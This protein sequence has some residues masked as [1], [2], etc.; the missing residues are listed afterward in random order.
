MRFAGSAAF[1]LPSTTTSMRPCS[2]STTPCASTGSPVEWVAHLAPPLERLYR[3]AILHPRDGSIVPRAVGAAARRACGRRRRRHPGRRAGHRR[4]GRRRHGRRRRRRLHSDAPARAA[5][6]RDARAGA[7]DRAIARAPL[8]AATLRTRRLRLLAAT[9]RRAA[10]SRR[11][12]RRVVR[13]GGH[14]GRRDDRADPGAARRASSSELVGYRPTVT[15][16]WAG[17]WGTT[18]DLVPLVGQV[19]GRTGVWVAGGYSG[20]GNVLGLACGDLVARAILGEE[21]PELEIFDPGRASVGQS[22]GRVRLSRSD[23]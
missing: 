21:P 16:R 15:D 13:D 9:P 18:P 3:G 2:A 1:D 5:H 7:R 8:R 6:S 14:R 11:Q 19:P 22:A 17:I 10:R 20:H 23:G 4:R 12:A